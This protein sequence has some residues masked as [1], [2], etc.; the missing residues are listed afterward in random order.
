MSYVLAVFVVLAFAIPALAI[1]LVILCVFLKIAQLLCYA[2]AYILG[3]KEC[4]NDESS[5]RGPSG[6]FTEEN[7]GWAGY[8]RE[9]LPEGNQQALEQNTSLANRGW[10]REAGYEE[11]VAAYR[12]KMVKGH[13]PSI[14]VF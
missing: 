4:F 13:D 12:K 1:G 8:A 10:P 9:G 2:L 6:R 3:G 7:S 14:S 11:G 5:I